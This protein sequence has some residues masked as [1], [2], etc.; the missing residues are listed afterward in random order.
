MIIKSDSLSAS[1]AKEY[2]KKDQEVIKSFIGKF[3][4]LSPKQAKDFRGKLEDLE[5]MKMNSKHISKIIDLLPTN[6]EEINK[7]FTD[8]SLDENE[9]NKIIDIVKQ[10]E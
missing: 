2:L 7:I 8:L 5:L 10:F 4:K 9:A 6:S 1:E 3:A